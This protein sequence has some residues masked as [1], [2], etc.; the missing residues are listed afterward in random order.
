MKFKPVL[1]ALACA[2]AVI[3]GCSAAA[4]LQLANSTIES[5]YRSLAERGQAG[6]QCVLGELYRANADYVEALR[7]FRSAAIQGDAAAEVATGDLYR[8]GQGV[9][10]DAAA[11]ARWYERAAASNNAD[12]L[13]KLGR[14]YEDGEGVPQDSETA[15]V[16]F[17]RAAELGSAG[18]H[19]S[20]GNLS[21]FS[22]NFADALSWYRQAAGRGCGEA[23]LNLAGMYYEG[24]GVERDY[25]EAHRLA[26]VALRHHVRDAKAFLDEIDRRLSPNPSGVPE[27]EKSGRR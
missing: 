17:R 9:L 15:T 23:L 11:A 19:N 7:W 8:E 4:R 22:R 26:G 16:L 1:R 13:W 3:A 18:A 14:L 27:S 10:P 24:L 5:E 6:A 12:A 20:L 2:L 21:L 25:Y